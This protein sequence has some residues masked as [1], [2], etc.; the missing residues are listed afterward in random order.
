MLSKSS[1]TKRF[2]WCLNTQPITMSAL[3]LALFVALVGTIAA[4]SYQ[5]TASAQISAILYYFRTPSCTGEP[6]LSATRYSDLV[7]NT[8]GP[9]TSSPCV[10]NAQ[11]FSNAAA[12]ANGFCSSQLVAVNTYA[13]TY[14]AVVANANKSVAGGYNNPVTMTYAYGTCVPSRSFANCYFLAVPINAVTASGSSMM[15]SYVA[16]AV[17]SFVS[18]LMIA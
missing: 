9:S 12:Q 16:L 7:L 17:A 18:F 14:D 1:P 4:Y 15:I 3:R 11:C 8:N 6:V 5:P 2:L 13:D 10:A